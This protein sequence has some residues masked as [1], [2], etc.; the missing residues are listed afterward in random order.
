MSD[1]EA[2]PV[3][4]SFP[5]VEFPFVFRPTDDSIGDFVRP[6]PSVVEHS[7][8][9]DLTEDSEK[10]TVHDYA[11]TRQSSSSSISDKAPKSQ[12]PI[13]IV[14]L[15]SA[16]PSGFKRSS[17]W[18]PNRGIVL[19]NVNDERIDADLGRPEKEAEQSV[20]KRHEQARMCNDFHLRNICTNPSCPFSHEPRLSPAESIA[21][22][23]LARRLLC[24]RGSACR[25]AE[26]W[27][28]HMCLHETCYLPNTCRFRAFHGMDHTAVTVW[29]ISGPRSWVPPG[30]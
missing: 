23:Y 3:L 5:T 18:N 28:G 19:L 2:E 15:P 17:S 11:L 6:E 4:G 21:L 20:R 25:G 1:F 12:Q 14:N 30:Q 24:Q 22:R 7:A 9:S 29:Q 27:Y 16:A 13:S 26:C 10:S 8:S